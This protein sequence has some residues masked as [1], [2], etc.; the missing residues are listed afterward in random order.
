LKI[1]VLGAECTGKTQLVGELVA[2][3]R[4]HGKSV[5]A[6]DEYLRSWCH[7]HK[8]TP[9]AHEQAHIAQTQIAR[10]LN[11]ASAHSGSILIADTSPLITALYSE[12]YFEDPSLLDEAIAH[13]RGYN[14]TLV[15][16]PDLPWM[17]DGIQRDGD[18]AR[19]R[20]DQLLNMRLA[21][22]GIA[23]SRIWGLGADRTQ[24]AL[25]LVLPLITASTA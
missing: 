1:A 5:V 21:E 7:Q 18:D 22:S 4:L 16:T 6:V 24:A 19:L 3:L 2:A 11:A 13:Q 20:F 8:R 17:A 9:L 10:E 12:L 23:F 14:V 25:K 15:C